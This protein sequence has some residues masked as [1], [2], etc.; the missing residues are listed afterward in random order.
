MR[1]T[2]ISVDQLYSFVKGKKRVSRGLFSHLGKWLIYLFRLIAWRL[3]SM[4]CEEFFKSR[5]RRRQSWCP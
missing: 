2:S 3:N 1:L 4:I 5:V